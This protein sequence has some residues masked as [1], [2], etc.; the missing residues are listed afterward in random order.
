MVRGLVSLSALTK[1]NA[2]PL[3]MGTQTTMPCAQ[4]ED[5]VPLGPLQSPNWVM[6]YLL[7]TVVFLPVSI[8]PRVEKCLG[9][10]VGDRILCL[11]ASCNFHLSV[12]VRAMVQAD[13]P[14]RHKH[15]AGRLSLQPTTNTNPR[16]TCPLCH[17]VPSSF[18]L[19][20]SPRRRWL[21]LLFDGRS[22]SLQHAS[23]S[24]GRI[25]ARMHHK[26]VRHYFQSCQ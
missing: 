12:A 10:P 5:S 24:Q 16:S 18:P 20:R 26:V 4:A 22:T 14:L 8:V 6:V 17:V 23:Q 15:V 13:L 19:P 21:L 9:L 25:W 7:S 2:N 3:Q 1:G 11:T